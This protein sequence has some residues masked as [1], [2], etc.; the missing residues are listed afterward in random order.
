MKP[1]TTRVLYRGDVR[2]LELESVPFS[3]RSAI[4]DALKPLV[5]PADS[6]ARLKQT[7]HS[8]F[9]SVYEFDI[10]T[11]KSKLMNGQSF[12]TGGV[13]PS[14]LGSF[15]DPQVETRLPFTGLAGRRLEGWFAEAGFGG[16][17]RLSA[18][19]RWRWFPRWWALV[20]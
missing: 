17:P 11:M 4:A 16:G 18:G 1:R 20:R 3:L 13:T 6:A 10:E 19:Y 2:K 14:P 15:E 12:P 5:N 7:L 9:E 8:V